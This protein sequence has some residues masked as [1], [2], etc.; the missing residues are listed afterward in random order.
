M[1]CC[2][3]TAL[4]TFQIDENYVGEPPKVEVTIENLNDNV[5]Q[6]F[7]GTMTGKFGKVESLQIYYH[8]ITKRHLGLARLIFELVP[9]A[10]E[11]VKQLHGKSVMGKQLNCYIDP[12]AASC[13]KMFQELTEEKKPEPAPEIPSADDSKQ[14]ESPEDQRKEIKR[15]PSPGRDNRDPRDR[16]D[17]R[18]GRDSDRHRDSRR[19]SSD[20]RGERDWGSSRDDRSGSRK[21]SNSDYDYNRSNSGSQSNSELPPPPPPPRIEGGMSQQDFQTNQY[22][23]NYGQPDY[24]VLKA[25]QYAAEAAAAAQRTGSQDL[26][27]LPPAD[28]LGDPEDMDG[29]G[30]EADGDGGEQGGAEGDHQVDLDT[31]LKM[32]MKGQTGSMPAFLLNELNGSG[33]E[34]EEGETKDDDEEEKKLSSELQQHETLRQFFPL[35]P[36]YPNGSKPCAVKHVPPAAWNVSRWQSCSHCVIHR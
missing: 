18:S 36:D 2:Y 1:T 35:Q 16:R 10:K 31:R 9:S 4:F 32:L 25:Q 23:A 34:V 3:V 29:D 24:W 8:P 26:G 30:D 19:K 27:E 33:S 28:I 11:C 22:D 15:P 17:S 14:D 5:D 20:H 12:Y 7:L 13:K 21:D 6:Q